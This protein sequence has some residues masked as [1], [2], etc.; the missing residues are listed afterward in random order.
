M[1]EVLQTQRNLECLVKLLRLY[2]QLDEVVDFAI[3]ELDND[4]IVV[5][6]SAVKDRVRKAI[7]KLIS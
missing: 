3:N 5:E 6:I 4:E 2:F 1:S 7:E